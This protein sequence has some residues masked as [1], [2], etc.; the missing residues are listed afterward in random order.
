MQNHAQCWRSS[1]CVHF[2]YFPQYSVVPAKRA[3]ASS[4]QILL[5][6]LFGD[7]VSP[8]IVGAVSWNST[9]RLASPHPHFIGCALL[10]DAHCSRFTFCEIFFIFLLCKNLSR[11]FQAKGSISKVLGVLWLCFDMAV[12]FALVELLFYQLLDCSHS[13]TSLLYFFFALWKVVSGGYV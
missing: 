9:I 3:T 2:L 6:H 10:T 11:S 13:S 5:S 7:S 4:V 12:I 8:T 1:L